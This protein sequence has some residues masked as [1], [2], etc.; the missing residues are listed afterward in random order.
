[1]K[2]ILITDPFTGCEIKAAR[3]SDGNI[4]FKHPITAEDVIAIYN[5]ESKTFTIPAHCFAYIETLTFSQAA[6]LLGVSRQR[7]STIAAT[8]VIKPV[9]INGQQRFVKADVLK[10]KHERKTGAPKKER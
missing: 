5:F 4:H 9:L 1:M 6:E 3:N 2:E 7:V 8:N 10:Y